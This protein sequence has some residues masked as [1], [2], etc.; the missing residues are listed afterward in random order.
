[1]MAI[2][3]EQQTVDL[4]E[5]GGWRRTKNQIATVRYVGRVRWSCSSRSASSF[6]P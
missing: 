4:R 6:S 3:S 5:P 2:A 1:M